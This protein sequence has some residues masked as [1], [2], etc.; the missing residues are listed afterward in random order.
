MTKSDELQWE[1]LRE[2]RTY[3]LRVFIDH[4][5]CVYAAD[6]SGCASQGTSID[7]CLSR[8]REAFCGIVASYDSDEQPIPWA[9]G[10][11]R[12]MFHEERH[13]TVDVTPSPEE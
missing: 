4:D 6:L 10:G 12:P 1:D 8:I 2:R 11:P 5:L 7:E 13:I 3:R 9:D